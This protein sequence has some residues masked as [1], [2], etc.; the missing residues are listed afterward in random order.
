MHFPNAE[1]NISDRDLLLKFID[2]YE[3][4]IFAILGFE[5]VIGYNLPKIPSDLKD[6]LGE[7]GKQEIRNDFKRLK[8]AISD[9]KDL[10]L[11]R[12]GL[13]GPQLRFKIAYLNS[14]ET[15]MYD[16][17]QFNFEAQLGKSLGGIADTIIDSALEATGAGVGIKEIGDVASD[18]IGDAI[19]DK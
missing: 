6:V 4:H 9:A 14:I 18:V 8:K 15:R 3:Q 10:A 16:G 7:S 17:P 2:A 13:L 11:K 19:D 12:H 1:T 5:E